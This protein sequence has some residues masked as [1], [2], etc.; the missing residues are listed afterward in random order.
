MQQVSRWKPFQGWALPLLSCKAQSRVLFKDCFVFLVGHGVIAD[1]FRPILVS[2]L[3]ALSGDGWFLDIEQLQ[4]H[5]SRQ[6]LVTFQRCRVT[7][8][9]VR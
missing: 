8:I 3:K 7:N 9:R 2:R 4:T 6:F 5:P 1:G